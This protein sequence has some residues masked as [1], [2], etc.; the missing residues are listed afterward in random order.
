MNLWLDDVR[1]PPNDGRTW[2]ICRTVGQAAAAMLSGNV[3]FASLDHDLGLVEVRTGEWSNTIAP[4]GYDFVKWM[5]QNDVW[6]RHRPVVHSA[7]PVGAAAMRQM[8]DR[9]WRAPCSAQEDA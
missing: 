2:T 3:E 6:P 9:F 8:I 4:T 7:N 1:D 5:A